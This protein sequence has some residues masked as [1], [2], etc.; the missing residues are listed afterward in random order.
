MFANNTSGYRG[1]SPE[2]GGTWR[3]GIM[4]NGRRFFWSRCA[5]IEE[6]AAAYNSL[7]RHH[8]GEQARLNTLPNGYP[9]FLDIAVSGRK[10]RRSHP[11]KRDI[12]HTLD[13]LEW[14]MELAWEDINCPAHAPEPS[15]SC[16][17]FVPPIV[18]TDGVEDLVEVARVG[19]VPTSVGLSYCFREVFG[20]QESLTD[21]CIQELECRAER[22][23][24]N[25]ERS[26]MDTITVTDWNRLI[27]V[28]ITARSLVKRLDY[29]LSSDL[30]GFGVEDA[31]DTELTNFAASLAVVDDLDALTGPQ[32][33]AAAR[34]FQIG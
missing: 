21:H 24:Q 11:R 5:T 30:V 34:P 10:G 17:E 2:S 15:R 12:A 6:A 16:P 4:S 20:K 26:A 19:F 29:L 14:A 22:P 28:L 23:Y 18:A 32:W 3:A 9:Q 33:R 8:H 1:V 25:R 13:R 31:I 7:A 27:T